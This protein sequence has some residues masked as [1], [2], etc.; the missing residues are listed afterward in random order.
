[1]S[2]PWRALGLASILLLTAC[3]SAARPRATPP[4]AAEATPA[5]P[6]PARTQMPSPTSLPTEAP[7]PALSEWEQVQRQVTQL[8][9]RLDAASDGYA[10]LTLALDQNEPNAAWC[11]GLNAALADFNYANEAASAQA[12]AA[13]KDAQG[14]P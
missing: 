5:R 6:D 12:L 1:M 4:P 13:L 9:S 2:M 14:C 11:G 7:T 10:G 3:A 8:R